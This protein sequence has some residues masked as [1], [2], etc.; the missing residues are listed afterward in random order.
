MPSWPLIAT[1]RQSACDNFWVASPAKPESESVDLAAGVV[2]AFQG[3]RG[4]AMRIDHP[5]TKPAMLVLHSL[6]P[7]PVPFAELASAAWQLLDQPPAEDDEAVLTE[8]LLGTHAT[9]LTE[10]HLHRPRWAAEPGER[11]AASPLLQRSCR[12]RTQGMSLRPAN[13]LIDAPLYQR[14]LVLLDG[15]RSRAD[16]LR[17]LGPHVASGELALPPKAAPEDLPAVIESCLRKAAEESLLVKGA[18]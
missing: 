15:T 3:P 17:K 4:G 14:L 2:E 18:S 8:V 13:V 6:W 9:G 12:G 5:L 11:P 7:R 10:L 16:L 1:R